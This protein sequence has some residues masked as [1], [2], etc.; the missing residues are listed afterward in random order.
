[1]LEHMLFKGTET[2]H[3]RRGTPIFFLLE[4]AGAQLNANT[5]QDGTN[6]YELLP[7][8]R[9]A[10]ALDIESERMR[11]ALLEEAEF[12]AEKNVVLNELERF[13]DSSEASLSQAVWETAF[14][15]HPYHHP[16]IGW[17]DDVRGMPAAKLKEFYDLYYWP[18][19]AT[20]TLIGDFD[21]ADVLKLVAE[22]F[23]RVPAAP[24][25]PPAIRE[26]EP[27]QQGP[28]SVKLERTTGAE[29]LM[30]AHKIPEGLHRDA[31]GLELLSGIL[32]HGKTSRLYQ[33][34]VQT[35]LA[36]DVGAG[37]SGTR[38]PGLFTTAVTLGPQVKHEDVKR[39]VL[40]VYEEVAQNGVTQEEL[41]R[42][43]T[44]I[45]ADSAYS[46][47]G[48]LSMAS[49]I[50]HAI[51]MG[52][53]TYFADHVERM[54]SYKPE[55]LRQIARRYFTES[56]MTTGLVV[57]SA[58]GAGRDAAGSAA[59][60]HGRTSEP[61]PPGAVALPEKV[62]QLLEPPVTAAAGPGY[63][64][65][66]RVSDAKNFKLL[67]LKTRVQDVVTISGSLR[68]AGTAYAGNTTVARLAGQMLDKGTAR[69][70]KLEI[71]SLLEDR[72]AQIHFGV[73]HEYLRFHARCLKKDAAFVA[74]LLAEQIRE[75]RF[76]DGEFQTL[77]KQETVNLR[78][79]MTNTG[80]MGFNAFFRAAFPEG[81]PHAAPRFEDQM[82]WLEKTRADDLRNFHER[83]YGAKGLLI[84]T[85]GDF[86][87]AEIE[88]AMRKAF[89]DW[90]VKEV[91]RPAVPPVPAPVNRRVPV[92]VP[93]KVK[94]DVLL[95]RA[96]PLL[97]SDPNYLAA[98]MANTILGGD[99]SARLSMTVRDIHGL[100][101][102]IRSG[103]AGVT[104]DVYGAWMVH[105]IVN[106][107]LLEKGLEK[108]REQL[109]LFFREGISAKE[110]E[111]R[112]KM[113]AGKFK[114]GLAT[115][116][117]LA[118]QIRHCEELGLGYGYLDDYSKLIGSLS[119]DQVNQAIRRYYNPDGLQCVV[120]GDVA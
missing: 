31:L 8:D 118:D 24:S 40:E 46:R 69:R 15:E 57:S 60:T 81:H 65:R 106:P 70:T 72:G 37:T 6:Y 93:G 10:L 34:L 115:T 2:Y 7:S 22:K 64:E 25:A 45:R 16:V 52:D 23:S 107:P 62:R 113:A 43:L 54:E 86:D 55:E 111:E 117:G 13:Y 39:K 91:S 47:D 61:P 44:Q 116:L 33:A 21:S 90:P 35:G 9:L 88:D 50:A 27:P 26:K 94:M 103:L 66:V 14:S 85:A 38:D 18:G 82:T 68:G 51:A 17:R 77:V 30:L 48:A 53:W 112:K 99:F 41:D 42:T 12:E 95:G 109:D 80:S 5:G 120:A 114:V 76:D 102:G 104:Q 11:G 20:L 4:S 97:R 71:A 63:R 89:G 100:T 59:G 58:A 32:S 19:N 110:L 83:H 75:P 28:K 101:Y 36:V 29:F 3:K 98:A 87:P 119:L 74:G 49:E 84:V 92:K 1:M 108:T 79:A 73:D 56:A 105:M 67:T 78:Y 96:F